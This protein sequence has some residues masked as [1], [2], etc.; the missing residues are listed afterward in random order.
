MTTDKPKSTRKT[1]QKTLTVAE[2]MEREAEAYAARV[3]EV[4][5]DLDAFEATL[6]Q[7]EWL[8]VCRQLDASREQISGDGSLRLLALG[9]LRE[10]REHGGASW[11]R[12]LDMTDREL[13]DLHG[14]PTLGQTADDDAEQGDGEPAEGDAADPA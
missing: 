5:A 3:A 7:R 8:L 4:Q 12:L 13:L 10:K 2:R 6:T 11:D 1:A 9:W 14:F